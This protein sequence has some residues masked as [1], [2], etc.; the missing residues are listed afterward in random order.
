MGYYKFLHSGDVPRCLKDETIVISSNKFFAEHPDPWIGDE[1]EGRSITHINDYTINEVTKEAIDIA[2]RVGV[3]LTGFK[4][5]TI[6]INKIK[7]QGIISIK[8]AS[9]YYI[10]SLSH[11]DLKNIKKDFDLHGHDNFRYDAALEIIDA[12]SYF[13][14][15]WC[16]GVDTQSGHAIKN[17][18]PKSAHH[19]VEYR[20]KI[21]GAENNPNYEPSSPLIKEL[22]YSWQCEHRALFFPN[23]PLLPEKLIIHVPGIAVFLRQVSFVDI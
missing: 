8:K 20:P 22:Q 10:Y 2:E 7:L 3:K 19:P 15:I 18:F 21:L 11:G 12:D 16:F 14:H 4:Q 9:K 13:K 17:I 23:S 5:D 6:G 1:N